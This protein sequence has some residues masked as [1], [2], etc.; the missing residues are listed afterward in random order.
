MSDQ[1]HIPEGLTLTLALPKGR[2][3]ETGIEL[4]RKA[5]LP[6]TIPEKSRLLR[7]HFG[8]IT[9]LELRNSDVP[10]YVD[11]G[12]ADAGIVGKDVLLEAGR[13]I[14]EP[15]DLK[16]GA[17]RLALIREKGANGPIN[18]VAS[19][20]PHV[21][22]QYLREKGSTAE[23]I[24]LNGNI[25]LACL[26]GLADAVVDIVETGSTLKANNLEEVETI[27]QSSARFVVARSSLKLKRAI[28][29]PLIHRLSELV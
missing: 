10:A 9:L 24:K 4:L 15:L 1:L 20:Y 26:T 8:P 19:K 27:A 16:Y 28:L 25:E 22:A 17:C 23:V 18:R 21:A 5:G 6:L 3:M 12:V 11:L 14:F 29:R 13:D 7:H 2:V